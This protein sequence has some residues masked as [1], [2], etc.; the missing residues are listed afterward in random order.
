LDKKLKTVGLK[1][2]YL[3]ADPESFEVFR[4]KLYL[5]L[6]RKYHPLLGLVTSAHF[7]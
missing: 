7:R 6:D 4:K 1:S 3:E 2:E 5:N